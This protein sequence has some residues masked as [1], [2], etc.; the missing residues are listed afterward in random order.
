MRKSTGHPRRTGNGYATN[1]DN[2]CMGRWW[3]LCKKLIN[4]GI[5][6]AW[7]LST[8][9]EEWAH[10]NLGGVTGIRLYKGIEWAAIARNGKSR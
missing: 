5:T 8:M 6:S 9:P 4:F 3:C 10:N 1:Q 2:E 7:E